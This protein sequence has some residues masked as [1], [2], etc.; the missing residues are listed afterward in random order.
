MRLLGLS[1]HWILDLSLDHDSHGRLI[2]LIERTHG[3]TTAH[4]SL[5]K[6]TLER[7]VGFLVVAGGNCYSIMAVI[8]SNNGT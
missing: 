8:G 3:A 1:N 5:L 7:D 2:R 4:R 6:L